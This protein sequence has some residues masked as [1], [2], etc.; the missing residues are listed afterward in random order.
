MTVGITALPTMD[1]RTENSE[2]QVPASRQ[3]LAMLFFRQHCI[4]KCCKK[5][6]SCNRAYSI[7]PCRY[8]NSFTGWQSLDFLLTH[9]QTM[10][11]WCFINY[12]CADLFGG[13]MKALLVFL[14]FGSSGCFLWFSLLCLK[15][16]PFDNSKLFQNF[17]TKLNLNWF[18]KIMVIIS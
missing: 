9:F 17:K 4:A 16:I 7:H 2:L 5:K 6:A 15:M 14:F 13:R 11:Y 8:N 12:R 18:S 1:Y 3:Q 10:S